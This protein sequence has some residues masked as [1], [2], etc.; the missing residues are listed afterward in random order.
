MISVLNKDIEDT[1][2][3][4]EEK[5][6]LSKLE[7][8][9]QKQ[10]FELAFCGHFSAGKST[11]LNTLLGAKVLPTSPIPTSANVIRIQNGELAL[12]IKGKDGIVKDWDGEIPW[13]QVR[14]WGM[15][16]NEISSMTIT[17]P[18]P[19]LSDCASILDTPGV[20]STDESH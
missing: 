18:L 6:R 7:D 13:D 14:T 11:I 19:F 2:L 16:G 17:A 3:N 12:S 10:F 20:D 15:K 5:F 4:I 9:N 1:V 8:K